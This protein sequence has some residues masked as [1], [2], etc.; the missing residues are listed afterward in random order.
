MELSSVFK[1]N[2]GP[3]SFTTCLAMFTLSMCLSEAALAIDA[4]TGPDPVFVKPK[5]VALAGLTNSESPGVTAV[6]VH[7]YAPGAYT[8]PLSPSPPH[9]DMN[10]RK[11]IV[12]QW[13]GRSERFVFNHEASYCPILEL[14]GGAG[15]CNQFFEGNIQ[16]EPANHSGSA[17]LFNINGRKERNSFV[18]IIQ[19]GPERVWVRWNYLAVTKTDDSQ[20]RLR[21]TEDYFAYP[22][23]LILRRLTYTSMMPD[24]YVGYSQQPVELFGIAPVGKELQDIFPRDPDHGDLLTLAAMDVYSDKTYEIFW[25]AENSVRRNGDDAMLTAISR[26]PGRAL[27]MPFK[28]KLLFAVMGDASGFEAE[29]SVLVDHCT[30]GV[31]SGCE[32]RQGI[33]D[34][35]PIGWLNSQASNWAPGSPYSYSFGSIGQ[36]FT[37][38]G[39]PYTAFVADYFGNARDMELNRWTEGRVFYV[40]LGA[41][42]HRDDIRRI[43]RAWLDLGP[44]CARPE[45]IAGLR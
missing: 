43:G 38:P 34:H 9:A 24:E 16:G 2:V 28:E 14:P 42:E 18:D 15:M 19:S 3:W 30:P 11:A 39:K 33:W 36:F 6:E 8:G 31:K 5:P 35:W 37:P 26:S 45:S 29:R 7:D 25:G 12:V 1:A 17:E 44:D 23:G 21:G 22:N 4:T 27:V 13:G 10:P 41:A 20:P 32:W 40:L